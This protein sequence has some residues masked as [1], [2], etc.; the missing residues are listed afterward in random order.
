MS[1]CLATGSQRVLLRDVS[2]FTAALPWNRSG[3]VRL[4]TAR[5]STSRGLKWQGVNTAS[6]T[7]GAV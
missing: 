7:P 3:A 5:S 2:V 1:C 4:G 6:P